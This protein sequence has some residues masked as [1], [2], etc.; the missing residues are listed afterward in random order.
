MQFVCASERR[1]APVRLS[2]GRWSR[3]SSAFMAASRTPT[4]ADDPLL[5]RL[6]SLAKERANEP[7]AVVQR[8]GETKSMGSAKDGV[9]GAFEH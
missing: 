5:G 9:V 2:P 3:A 1:C 4:F 8:Q 6:A 7:V